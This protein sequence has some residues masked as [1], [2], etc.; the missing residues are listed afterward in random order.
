MKHLLIIFSLFLFSFT[1]ISCAKE[2]SE[3]ASTDNSTS[4]TTTNNSTTTNTTELEGTWI[5]SCYL[6]TDNSSYYIDTISVTGTDLSIKS[7]SH[8]DSGC[9][10]DNGTA[11]AT[12]NFL[13]I[14]DEVTFSSGA[15]GH[16]FTINLSSFTYTPETTSIVSSLNTESFCGY[17]DWELNSEKDITG[18]TCGSITVPVANTTYLGL[19]KLVGNNLF[20]GTLNT[21]GSYPTTVSTAITYVK[22]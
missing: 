13:S 2:E 12:F 22:Q 8:E 10:T 4:T 15:T 11:V 3:T 6:E 16:K 18:K 9:N 1:V 5:T 20:L 7:E 19:Y 14:G 21:T 17:S